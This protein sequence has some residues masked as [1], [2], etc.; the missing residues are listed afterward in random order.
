MQ[1]DLTDEIKKNKTGQPASPSILEEAKTINQT[2]FDATAAELAEYKEN[3]EKLLEEQKDLL[4]RYDSIVN[5]LKEA[6]EDCDAL[7]EQ[8]HNEKSKFEELLGEAQK[9]S[10]IDYDLLLEEYK[11]AQE[12]YKVFFFVTSQKIKKMKG[13]EI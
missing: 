11:I 6:K 1:S 12:S 3:Y 9:D 8:Y 4:D 7:L 13:I 5:E 10:K 2:K